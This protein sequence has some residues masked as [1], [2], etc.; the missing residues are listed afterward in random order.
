MNLTSFPHSLDELP[1]PTPRVPIGAPLAPRSVRL[2]LDAT[3]ARFVDRH[4][5]VSCLR[6]VRHAALGDRPRVVLDVRDPDAPEDGDGPVRLWDKIDE[7]LGAHIVHWRSLP[8]RD[9]FAVP[10]E[11]A[12]EA[13]EWYAGARALWGED[14]L[15]IV[16]CFAGRQRSATIAYALLRAVHG[17]SHDAALARVGERGER[18]DRP[19]LYPTWDLYRHVAEWCD[20]RVNA[21]R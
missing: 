12:Q 16:H 17:L 6:G 14:M 4:L 2:A 13:V 11:A 1:A 9:G 21:A 19:S 3:N 7:A 10:A 20:A 18:C 5:V 8:L 15:V